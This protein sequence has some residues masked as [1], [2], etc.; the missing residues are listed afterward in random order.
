MKKVFAVC[1]GFVLVLSFQNCGKT[2][3]ASAS[4]EISGPHILISECPANASCLPSLALQR[5]EVRQV[6]ELYFASSGGFPLP[7]EAQPA[8]SPAV[9]IELRHDQ[10]Q[11]VV[12]LIPVQQTDALQSVC[13]INRGTEDYLNLMTN[14]KSAYLAPR[15]H[16][17]AADGGFVELRLLVGGQSFQHFF[18]W[19]EN[20]PV[21]D[22]I[23]DG[24]ALRQQLTTL[25][26][27]SCLYKI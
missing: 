6:T 15:R 1:F 2:S 7:Q 18:E 17:G 5:Y 10:R 12:H 16:L 21:N 3:F 14:L 24:E 27:L 11:L 4:S 22:N 9:R 8:P 25:S 26:Q 20:A 23:F 13:S 19:S